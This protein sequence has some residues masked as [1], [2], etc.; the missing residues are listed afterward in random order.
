MYQE[1]KDLRYLLKAKRFCNFACDFGRHDCK[2]PDHPFSL[3]EG[4]SGILYFLD[5]MEKILENTEENIKK[6]YFPCYYVS[7][8]M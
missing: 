7:G 3:F 1:T 8:T 5:D 4:M 6:A 2:T